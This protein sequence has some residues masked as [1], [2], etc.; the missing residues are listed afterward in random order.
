MLNDICLAVN[1]S[2]F[3]LIS[4]GVI[5][6]KLVFIGAI[7]DMVLIFYLIRYYTLVYF[8]LSRSELFLNIAFSLMFSITAITIYTRF[9]SRILKEDGFL[10][11]IFVEYIKSIHKLKNLNVKII[12]GKLYYIPI[13]LLSIFT[14]LG[15]QSLLSE[16]IIRI[17]LSIFLPISLYAV[18]V[19][20]ALINYEY[21]Q[22]RKDKRYLVEFLRRFFSTEDL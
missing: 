17:K 18:I 20:V 7:I 6:R 11:K 1:F 19:I 16:L 9:F 10:I 5:H 4:F 3:I 14:I 13:F 22:H 21:F 12:L 8:Y 2:V 15:L